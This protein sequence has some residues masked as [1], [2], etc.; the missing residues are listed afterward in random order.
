METFVADDGATLAYERTGSGP[1]VLFVH[2][3]QARAR[4]WRSL[5]DPLSA[6]HT[7]IGLDLRGFGAS[8]AA[9]GPYTIVRASRDL[10]ALLDAVGRAE[11]AIVV[12]HSM[13]G[14]IAQRFAID[15]PDRVLA[16]VLIAPVPASGL[17]LS[18]SARAFFDATPGN[19][20]ATHR[21]IDALAFG[22]TFA[23]AI[24]QELREAASAQDPVAARAS[25]ASW[26]DAA[27]AGEARTIAAPTLVV[28]ASN[29][30]PMTPA[31]LQERVV[32]VIPKSALVVIPETGHYPQLE[33]HAL[34]LAAMRAFFA[35]LA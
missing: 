24:A 5:S 35:D 18:Q 10:D 11:P 25:F 15:R 13:G 2:G 28:S 29:D 14:A 27:F 17:P 31:F 34:V 1:P 23:P 21:F 3:W 7:C 33:A 4:L 20:D 22:G 32:D 16:L 26:V 8:A 19:A 9:P 30:R 6:T 12:G